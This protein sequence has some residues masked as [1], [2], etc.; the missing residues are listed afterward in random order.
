[1]PCLRWIASKWPFRRRLA[2]ALNQKEE[3]LELVVT[4]FFE[5]QVQLGHEL[6]SIDLHG[7]L[8]DCLLVEVLVLVELVLEMPEAPLEELF[9]VLDFLLCCCPLVAILQHRAQRRPVDVEEEED[10]GGKF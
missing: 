9:R 8:A 1:M 2:G 6:I 10:S 7:P 5:R 4:K 3:R